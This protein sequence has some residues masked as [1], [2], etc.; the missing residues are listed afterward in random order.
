MRIRAMLLGLLAAVALLGAAGRAEAKPVQSFKLL[1]GGKATI[2]FEAFCVNFG[3]LF[4]TA[5]N[6]PDGSLA[7][8]KA[9]A[10]LEYA[11]DKGLT[12]DVKQALQVEYAIWQL[13]G[14]TNS[15]KGDALAQDV[16][17]A[18]EAAK[19][20]NPDGTSILDAAKAGDVTITLDSWQPIGE[21]QQITTTASDHFYGRGQLTVVNAAQGALTLYMPSGTLFPPASNAQNMAGIPTDV[22]VENP[23][24]PATG[25][26]DTAPLAL[27]VLAAAGML[28]LGWRVR[29]AA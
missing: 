24:L 6:G 7:P 11:L 9:R 13:I 25:D 12:A 20:V 21:K 15:P 3:K 4:P 29:R 8:D 1:P 22:K 5:I 23:N 17:K 10:A 14:S 27:L 18:A 2:T 19:V 28:A 16:I 26:T